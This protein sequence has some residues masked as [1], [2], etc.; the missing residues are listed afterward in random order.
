M[1]ARPSLGR[2]Y[3]RVGRAEEAVAELTKGLALDYYGDIHYSLFQ[4]YRR[5]GKLDEAKM[6]LDRSTA[7]RKRSFVR[8]RGK[9]DRWIK[10]E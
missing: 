9:L 1:Q 3:L 8:D 2:A 7:M 5:L 10:G 4:A 6:A